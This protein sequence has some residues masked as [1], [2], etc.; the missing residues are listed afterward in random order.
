MITRARKFKK[1]VQTSDKCNNKTTPNFSFKIR[2]IIISLELC[3]TVKVKSYDN[4]KM[5]KHQKISLVKRASGD[6]VVIYS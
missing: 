5:S 1:R 2:T 3:E 6:L 4:F